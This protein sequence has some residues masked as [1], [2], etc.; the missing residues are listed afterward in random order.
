M[1]RWLL[2]VAV[3]VAFVAVLFSGNEP[4]PDLAVSERE[5]D[6]RVVD[7]A[8][9][10]D[11]D[12]VGEAFARL[13]EAGWDGVALAFESEQANQGEAQRSGRL[14][15]EEWDVD[16]VVVAVARPG[17]FEVGPNGGRR[18]VGVEARNAREVPGELRERISDEVMAP[19]AEE[20]AWTAAFVE[21]A[22]ALEA[23]L[24]PGG[25]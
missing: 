14:L 17:D 18:A 7:P 1:T 6:A 20:N 13:D 25:P 2:V 22:E 24:E 21:A 8:G 11:G 19:H 10:L 5:G 15:L 4:D 16:L 3:V 23:E 12:A 9:V